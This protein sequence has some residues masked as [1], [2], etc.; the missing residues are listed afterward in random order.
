MEKHLQTSRSSSKKTKLAFIAGLF[1][2]EGSVEYTRRWEKKHTRKKA[3][4][5]RR[6][7]CE[8][9]MTDYPVLHWLH[10]TLGYGTLRPRKSPEGNKPQ[11]RWRCGFRNC[12]KFAQQMLPHAIVKYEKLKQIVDHYH[13]ST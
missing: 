2:G 12:N 10:Q 1:D 3:Y 9:G 7:I 6:I 13:E 5:C 8:I 11:W 4:L